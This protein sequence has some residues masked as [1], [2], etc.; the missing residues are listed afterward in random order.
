MAV[1]GLKANGTTNLRADCSISVSPLFAGVCHRL[2]L[3]TWRLLHVQHLVREVGEVDGTIVDKEVPST[4]FMHGGAGVEVFGCPLKV[5]V[6]GFVVGAD[7]VAALLFIPQLRPV[8]SIWGITQHDFSPETSYL[9]A[10]NGVR[11]CFH[12]ICAI[13]IS[14]F[15]LKTSTIPEY[16]TPHI[17]QH[18]VHQMKEHG[19]LM[20]THH[21]KLHGACK[22]NSPHTL[23]QGIYIYKKTPH[24]NRNGGCYC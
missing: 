19:R 24:E 5:N 12:K 8:H 3:V 4:V 13:S 11:V 18:G 20:K 21:I 1:K 16:Q 15:F 22:W 7:D 23:I 9:G 10:K 6:G 2:R 17:K 14:N